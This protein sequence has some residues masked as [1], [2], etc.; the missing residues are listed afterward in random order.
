MTGIN[1]HR[2]RTALLWAGLGSITA[3]ATA[4]S[5]APLLELP[6]PIDVGTLVPPAP[7]RIVVPPHVRRYDDTRVRAGQCAGLPA[8][9]LVSPAVYAETLNDLATGKRLRLE[10]AALDRL[11]TAERAAADELQAACRARAAE[12]GQEVE[13]ERRLSTWKTIGVFV[14]GALVGA[15]GAVAARPARP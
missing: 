14:V 8:G 9:I 6:P 11:R 1:S 12:L 3:C 5:P 15:V 4:P 7:E 2:R 13:W 10:V